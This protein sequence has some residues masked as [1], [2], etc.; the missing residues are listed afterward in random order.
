MYP[1]GA[2]ADFGAHG[3]SDIRELTEVLNRNTVLVIMVEDASAA[4]SIDDIAR[5]DGVD[6]VVVG[7]SDLSASLGVVGTGK[8]PK[9]TAAIDRILDSCRRSGTKFGMPI[10][11]PAYP[12]TAAE[13]RARGA[14]LLTSGSDANSMLQGFRSAVK[15]NS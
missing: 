8:H 3:L 2:A 15:S 9:L 7:P 10:Q 4:D 1:S 6:I 13:L 14:W 5:T 11:H 12:Q